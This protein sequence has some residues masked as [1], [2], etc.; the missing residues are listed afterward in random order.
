M[1]LLKASTAASRRSRF[2]AMA[3]ATRSALPTPFTSTL[4]DSISTQRPS[5]SNCYPPDLVKSLEGEVLPA[6]DDVAGKSPEARFLQPGP[7]QAQCQQDGSENDQET[8]HCPLS[9]RSSNRFPSASTSQRQ[10]GASQVVATVSVTMA[11]PSMRQPAARSWRRQWRTAPSNPATDTSPTGSHGAAVAILSRV[12]GRA[13]P[14][15]AMRRFTSSTGSA[16]RWP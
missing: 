14:R 16:M 12:T 10:P 2:G 7:E 5:A 9:L 13:L 3:S 15:T 6:H 1:D 8:L 11:G 4:A